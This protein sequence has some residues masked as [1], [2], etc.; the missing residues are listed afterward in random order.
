MYQ[1]SLHTSHLAQ[2]SLRK[3]STPPRSV[4]TSLA[5][6]WVARVW[7]SYNHGGD[8]GDMTG[9]WFM[10]VLTKH[11]RGYKHQEWNHGD[12]MGICSQQGGYDWNLGKKIGR[13]WPAMNSPMDGLT[14]TVWKWGDDYPHWETNHV[15]C[16]RWAPSILGDSSCD[17]D[18][19]KRSPKR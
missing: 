3:H 13:L 8:H 6:R 14:V 2:D 19:L 4:R 11:I 17:P 5:R 7:S 15:T 9:G 10:S 1:W 12:I 16:H 18:T